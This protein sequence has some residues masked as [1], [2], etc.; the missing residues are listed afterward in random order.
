MIDQ[1][2]AITFASV[3]FLTQFAPAF[4]FTMRSVLL[5]FDFIVT[6]CMMNQ[7]DQKP[8][9]FV[10][11]I[12]IGCHHSRDV[13]HTWIDMV[14]I[15]SQIIESH[16]DAH[17]VVDI[18]LYALRLPFGAHDAHSLQIAGGGRVR[19]GYG[20]RFEMHPSHALRQ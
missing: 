13:L 6:G 4:Y 9:G 19:L 11:S 16:R 12:V 10:R 15:D 18:E 5:P 2:P 17:W 3:R 1:A 7:I 20:S 8:F 14:M